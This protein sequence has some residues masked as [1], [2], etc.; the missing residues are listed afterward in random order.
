MSRVLNVPKFLSGKV[1][2]MAEF[3]LCDVF[4]GRPLNMPGQRLTGFK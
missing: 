2:N 4:Y 1:L 3:S